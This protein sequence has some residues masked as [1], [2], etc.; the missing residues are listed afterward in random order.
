MAAY[1]GLEAELGKELWAVLET[2]R[3]FLVDCDGE[4]REK[5]ADDNCLACINAMVVILTEIEWLENKMASGGK[6]K[7]VRFWCLFMLEMGISHEIRH[8]LL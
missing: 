4:E 7:R 5:Q 3:D 2:P 8:L 6:K 1:L